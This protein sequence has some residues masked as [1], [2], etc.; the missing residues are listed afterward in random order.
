M[1]EYIIATRLMDR[2]KENSPSM[3]KVYFLEKENTSWKEGEISSMETELQK[4]KK[5]NLGTIICSPDIRGGYCKTFSFNPR[6]Y[7]LKMPVYVKRIIFPKSKDNDAV[8]LNDVASSVTF[9]EAFI[10]GFDRFLL[11]V[12]GTEAFKS[13]WCPKTKFNY[14]R[15]IELS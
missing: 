14:K 2:S 13:E 11:D 5:E 1:T 6:D 8:I 15:R 10:A 12:G 7:S 4:L 3:H 9:S